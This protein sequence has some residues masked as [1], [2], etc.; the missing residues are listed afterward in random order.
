MDTL[1]ERLQQ[2]GLA[3]AEEMGELMAPM[4]S[5][6]SAAEDAG[7]AAQLLQRYGESVQRIGQLAWDCGLPGL[8]SVCA[9][10]ETNL[11]LLQGEERALSADECAL[12]EGWPMLLCG[13]LI[14]HADRESSLALLQSLSATWPMTMPDESVA[15]ELQK[16]M[17]QAAPPVAAPVDSFADAPPV[18]ATQQVEREMLAIL[19]SE[20]GQ[21]DEQFSSDLA[22][23]TYGLPDERQGALTNYLDFMERLKLTVESVGLTA[24]SALFARLMQHLIA[25]TA[26]LSAA[27]QTV[28]KQLPEYLS[29]YL[30][31][32]DDEHAAAALAALLSDAAWTT[33]VGADAVAQWQRALSDVQLTDSAAHQ[34]PRQ[35]H[36]AA[37]DVALELPGDVN[38]ELLDGLLQ[39]LPVQVRAFTDAIAQIAN[40]QGS[41]KDAERAMRAAH[42]LKGAANTVGVTGIANLTHH[43]EDILVAL[44][45]AGQL[46]QQGLAKV[47]INAGDCLEEMGE[48][49]LGLGDT[50]DNA[51]EILQQVLDSANRID[52]DGVD[53][54]VTEPARPTMSA[55]V[56]KTPEPVQREPGISAPAV[57]QALR[58]PASVVEELLRLAGETLISNSQIQEQLRQ[59]A[60]QAALIRKQH[61]LIQQLAAELEELVDI[62]GI[63]TPQQSV[64]KQ[65]GFD[66][67]EF[68]QYSELQ[69][70]SRRMIEAVTDVQEMAGTA[71]EQLLTLDELLGEQ[72]R[73]QVAN[74]HA[75][76]RTRMV[77][78]GSVTSRLQR[79]VRQT[80][81]LLDK[82]VDFTIK[83]ENTSIDGHVL[84]DLMD[85]LMHILRNAVD[86][87]IESAE[88][89]A[90]AGKPL[91]GRVEL[92]FAREGNSIV[93][94]CSD[95]GAGLDYAAI[96]RIAER[97]GM[98]KSEQ[99]HTEEE[100]ARLI[101]TPGFSTRDETSQ[102]SGRGVG[103]DVVYSRV[104]EMKGMLALH[105][106]RGLGLTVELR[107]PVTLLS[108]HT[109]IVRQRDKRLAISSRGVEDIRYVT[110]EQ[111]M[112][113]GPRK[114]FREGE[115]M[116][117]L[118]R[119]EN[120]LSLP[121]DQR[122]QDRH[123]FPILLTRLNDGT[124]NAV[125]VQEL[126]D[127]R[128]VVMKNFGRY[129]PRTQGVIG[130][131]ILGDGGVVPVIDLVELLHV[132]MH[133][134]QSVHDPAS[135][136]ESGHHTENEA[137]QVLVVDD[138]L[139]ARRS[140]VQVMKDAGYEVRTANDGL[141]AVNILEKFVPD[142]ILSDMEMPRMNG[143]ELTANVRHAEHTKHV[144][145]I[146]ITSRSTE[147][148]RQMSASAG[149]NAHIVKPF[150]DAELLQH[151]VRLTKR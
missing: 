71:E 130:A 82:A 41:L 61:L 39:E 7:V 126:I 137:L 121:T 12:L 8:Q 148:H 151:V 6:P 4:P 34:A 101:L 60:E 79:G 85:P 128:E 76:I 43:L 54:D 141:D 57:E 30:A 40:G 21:M 120:L 9:L 55:S 18:I 45:E 93:V 111:F 3:T 59:S 138:S 48:F 134:A 62:R 63:V 73:L 145:V 16:L 125:Q 102:V 86:H 32:P 14:N 36:A 94:R 135:L 24:L 106:R 147:K 20:L 143:L 129:V 28:L 136:S 100:L 146:M 139:S 23:A 81:R 38:P 25:L 33:P 110:R 105:S 92:A 127:S 17:E 98:L 114:F 77:S 53:A 27:Q 133:R 2:F 84:N 118:V 89:R 96:R 108:T 13:Y 80:G 68:E 10:V 149:V 83:G 1:E 115:K 117:G 31:A 116:Y 75:V 131:V 72:R 90:G 124:V 142:I 49:L 19:A 123:G 87:G 47:L 65:D 97:K 88:T 78:V 50:P 91:Q 95:D 29:A 122:A 144:P 58:V 64:R 140:L 132:P 104:Q 52:H 26:G 150:S 46:P 99:A 112:E 103:M 113:I 119:L 67:L 74:Q 35:T 15:E 107:L 42:T 22:S 51:Q 69:T 66:A 11:L 44:I 70:I 5:A 109:L 56:E 37:E